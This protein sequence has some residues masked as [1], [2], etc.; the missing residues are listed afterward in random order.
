MRQPSAADDDGRLVPPYIVTGGRTRSDGADLA[1]E[2]LVTTT[3]EGRDA[4]G[5]H[6]FEQRRILMMCHEP[7]SIAEVAATLEVPAGVARVLIGDLVADGTL[8]VS[9]PTDTNE[10]LIRRLIDGVRSL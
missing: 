2:T 1:L 8:R 10:Q 7:L 6:V 4:A 5:R 3:T 9:R